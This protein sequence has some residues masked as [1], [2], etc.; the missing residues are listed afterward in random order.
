MSAELAGA[1]PVRPGIFLRP[2]GWPKARWLR[3]GVRQSRARADSHSKMHVHVQPHMES[4]TGLSTNAHTH[5]HMPRY[6]KAVVQDLTLKSS[7]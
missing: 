6:P 2:G 7:S 5:M 1:C 3:P 4:Y